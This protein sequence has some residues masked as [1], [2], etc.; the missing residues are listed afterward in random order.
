MSRSLECPLNGGIFDFVSWFL[1]LFAEKFQ[2]SKP[3]SKELHYCSASVDKSGFNSTILLP[4]LP[5]DSK[6]RFLC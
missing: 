5:S 1:D 2:V 3:V 4:A 6:Y